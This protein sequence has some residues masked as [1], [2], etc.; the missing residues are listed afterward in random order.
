MVRR[1]GSR[2]R[3]SEPLPRALH[4]KPVRAVSTTLK[5][6]CWLLGA[7]ASADDVGNVSQTTEEGNSKVTYIWSPSSLNSGY[8]GD[9]CLLKLSLTVLITYMNAALITFPKSLYFTRP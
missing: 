5:L 8:L 4:F 2:S 7:S 9:G 1:E 3:S 6:A